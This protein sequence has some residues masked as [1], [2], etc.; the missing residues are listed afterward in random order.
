MRYDKR[1]QR[2]SAS[3]GSCRR[4]VHRRDIYGAQ[5]FELQYKRKLYWAACSLDGAR[6]G[7]RAHR[8]AMTTAIP[9]KVNSPFHRAPYDGVPP[10]VSCRQ[11]ARLV[12]AT[13]VVV[14]SRAG[15]QTTSETCGAARYFGSIQPVA[16]VPV[17]S[18]SD[19]P[20]A[21]A[22]CSAISALR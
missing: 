13:N 21:C 18:P 15:R 14:P 22:A 5:M 2:D 8:R 10:P 6:T 1:G 16:F 20:R 3:R 12:V 9:V 19:R 17:V 11:R 4:A 7:A